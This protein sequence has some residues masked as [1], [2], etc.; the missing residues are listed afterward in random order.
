MKELI[1][2]IKENLAHYLVLGVILAIGFGTFWYY[3]Y[4][5]AIQVLVVFLTAIV[6]FIWG[7]I[8][9]HLVGDLNRK[10]VLEYL[11]TAVLG[12]IVIWFLLLRA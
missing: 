12:F 2:K 3:R 10:V 6:Y 11:S 1:E 5:S 9:H 7:V 4:V 8:H